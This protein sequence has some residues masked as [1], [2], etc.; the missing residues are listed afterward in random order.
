[1]RQKSFR[2]AFQKLMHEHPDV[3]DLVCRLHK[4]RPKMSI[5]SLHSEMVHALRRKGLRDDEYP[6]NTN[7]WGRKPLAVYLK[8]FDEA[9][10][11]PSLGPIGASIPIA[12]HV[13]LRSDLVV[14]RS[15]RGDISHGRR[16]HVY[17]IGNVYH[18]HTLSRIALL[19]GKTIKLAI[20]S[21]DICIISA[22]TC[23]DQFI[24]N[25]FNKRLCALG[26]PITLDD[27]RRILKERRR[28]RFH[29]IDIENL[30]EM[31]LSH[32]SQ[33]EKDNRD[34]Q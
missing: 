27:M 2:G 33:K 21:E 13:P 31:A 26:Y 32:S 7:E 17:F 4:Q 20:N 11:L 14:D 1:M 10:Y 15:V 12:P 23:K 28:P 24:D 5:S 25:L 3:V 29:D 30:L 8:E 19:V 9:I 22:Y 6:F 18:G 16:P 34:G